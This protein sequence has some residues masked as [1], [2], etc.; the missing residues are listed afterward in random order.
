MP[1]FL[2][3]KISVKVRGRPPGQGQK[4]RDWGLGL[5]IEKS[6]IRDWERESDLRDKGFRDSTL[7]TKEFRDSVQ[8]LK[9]FR[10]T[11]P[12]PC[13]PLTSTL[14]RWL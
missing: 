8:G 2:N 1:L 13:R 11:V 4:I 5:R 14:G 12:V 10:D 7:G 9:I 3:R 6:G